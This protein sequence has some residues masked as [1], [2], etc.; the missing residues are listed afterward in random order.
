MTDLTLS[1]NNGNPTMTSRE[2]ADLTGKRHPDVKRDIIKMLNELGKDVRSFAH[3]YF[4]S[5]NREQWEFVLDRYHTEVLI[6]GYD[7]QRRAAVIDR[8]FQLESGDSVPRFD[9]P[10]TYSG[11]LRLAADAIEKNQLLEETA[12]EQAFQIK[13][14]QNLFEGGITPFEFA[15][16]LNGVNCQKVNGALEGRGWLYKDPVG[17]WRA[18]SKARDL[19]LTERTARVER[20]SGQAMITATPILLQRGAAL[21]HK[22]Y[23]HE[24]LPMK[25][26]WDG[27]FTHQKTGSDDQ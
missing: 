11:A 14:L 16:R 19:Y 15:K 12:K 17:S 2:I 9:V 4:D 18:S 8:W 1:G 24:Q 21:L 13:S 27:T 3:I 22:L 7:I 20:S 5:M 25:K 10:K 23:L 26:A 6:T